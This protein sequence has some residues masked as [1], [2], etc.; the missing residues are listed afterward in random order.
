MAV[1]QQ[2]LV[3]ARLRKRLIM[4]TDAPLPQKNQSIHE[5]ALRF[6]QWALG[7]RI[8]AGVG[9]RISGS[10]PSG[11]T[12]SLDSAGDPSTESFGWQSNGDNEVRIYTGDIFYYGRDVFTVAQTD[13]TVPLG[14]STYYVYVTASRDVSGGLSSPSVTISPTKPGAASATTWNFPLYEFTNNSGVITLEKRRNWGDI[15]LHAAI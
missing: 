12:L 14:G 10:T 9:V 7:E 15:L 1:C 5:W 4:P 8:L 11:K 13:L 6:R 3:Y 2:G